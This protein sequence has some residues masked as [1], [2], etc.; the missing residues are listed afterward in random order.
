MEQ[1]L[2]NDEI[3]EVMAYIHSTI[4]GWDHESLVL[5][6]MDIIEGKVD[7]QVWIN[8]WKE[9]MIKERNNAG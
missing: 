3:G 2:S 6:I 4:D 9:R 8:G 5:L 1:Q 7:L